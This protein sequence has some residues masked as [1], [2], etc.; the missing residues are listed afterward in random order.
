MSKV[1]LEKF[2]ELASQDA[3]MKSRLKLA[4]NQNAFVELL[5]GLGKQKGFEFTASDVKGAL[6]HVAT[7][8]AEL[9]D[10]ELEAVAGGG[11]DDNNPAQ[12]LAGM[13]YVPGAC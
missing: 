4:P 10:A 5:V 7:P 1:N 9:S 12:M 8:S 3:Q 6:A 13:S 2:L 11:G